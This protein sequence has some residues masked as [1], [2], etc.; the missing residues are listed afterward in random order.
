METYYAVRT[1]P[2]TVLFTFAELH[3]DGLPGEPSAEWKEMER[4]LQ[5]S[6][7][8]LPPTDK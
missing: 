7:K 2:D 5:E 6:L 8:V 1:G 3:I 4:L